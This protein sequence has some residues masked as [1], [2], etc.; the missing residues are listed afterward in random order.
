MAYCPPPHDDDDDDDDD[1][2]NNNDDDDDDENNDDTEGLLTVACV[3]CLVE[4]SSRE[5]SHCDV[6][7]LITT[8]WR[9]WKT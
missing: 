9:T 1:N 8:P 5:P 3:L 2:D 7:P 4:G 6:I